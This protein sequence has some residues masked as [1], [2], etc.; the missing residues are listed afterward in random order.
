VTVGAEREAYARGRGAADGGAAPASFRRDIQGLR[1][2]AV[3]MVVVFHTGLALPGGYIGVDVFFVVS[4]FVITAMLR[5]QAVKGRAI[6]LRSF[7]ARRARRLLPMLTLTLVA[8]SVLSVFLLP[9][10]GSAWVT[11]RTA[12]AGAFF[13]ANTF[14]SRLSA[15][16]FALPADANALVHIWSLSVE[17]QFYLAAPVLLAGALALLRRRGGDPWRPAL[18]W[19][20]LGLGVVSL[21]L[22]GALNGGI[23]DDWLT[24][25]GFTSGPTVAFYSAPTRAW[26]FLAGALLALTAHR[27]GRVPRYVRDVAGAVGLGAIALC[28][29]WF[30]P[31][32][33]R[34]T[35]LM[36]I[37][38]VGTVMAL[39]PGLTE[40][41]V[42][43]RTLGWR[44]LVWVGDRSYGWYL[45]H[46]P[47]IAFAV[48]GAA[49]TWAV[50]AA[51]L[52]ALALAALAKRVVEDPV[53]LGTAWRGR[54]TVVLVATA[55][56]LPLVVAAAMR[57]VERFTVVEPALAATSYHVPTLAGC[58]ARSATT[59]T[60]DSPECT[61]AVSEPRGRIVLVG[62]SHAEMWSEAVI[63]AGN[64]LDYDVSVSVMAGCPMIVGTMRTRDGVPDVECREFVERTVD[65]LVTLRP[66]LVV[67]SGAATGVTRGSADAWLDA[68]GSWVDGS[69]AVTA[70]WQEGTA[71]FVGR[72]SAAGIPVVVVHDVPYQRTACPRVLALADADRCARG[73]T[74]AE[75]E[76]QQRRGRVAEQRAVEAMSTAMVLDPVPWLCE[77][78]ECALIRDG[79]W[80]YRDDDHLSVQGAEALAP[81][82]KE[83][84]TANGYG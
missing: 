13:N 37:P 67:V 2:V 20:V 5:R 66:A 41:A 72:M 70:I 25:A 22:F 63:A 73:M 26:E 56:L 30:G 77:G 81:R 60:L 76:E 43:E 55:V 46:W 31:A 65:R 40:G 69:E 12:A 44:P 29:M 33:S 71:A 39:T 15:D 23:L 1:A 11:I 68:G 62:D 10:D 75:A 78:D 8:T 6:S 9:P 82:W 3:L 47:L 79:V 42:V 57:L 61:W 49:T 45:F 7:Y 51:A 27:V 48:A 34:S 16:Y 58:S 18:A 54:R 53:R 14:L 19:G 35:L 64:Q 59:A 36:V 21:A 50:A 17:E 80:M 84:L 4:G 74:R 28:A 32:A 83:F 38:V 24:R 52:S